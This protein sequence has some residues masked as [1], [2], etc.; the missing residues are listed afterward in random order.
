M[1]SEL[2][3]PEC[4]VFGLWG[5]LNRWTAQ[6]IQ[7]KQRSV[8]PAALRSGARIERHKAA[9]LTDVRLA[10]A[11]GAPLRWAW[12]HHQEPEVS[13]LGLSEL[14]QYVCLAARFSCLK[15]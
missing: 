10:N 4:A 14:R 15:A 3:W 7:G 6:V 8:A 5:D 9:V 12:V 1:S 13:R 2:T 11:A